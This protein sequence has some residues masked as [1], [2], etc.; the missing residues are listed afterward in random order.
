MKK[1]EKIKKSTPINK[2]KSFKILGAEKIIG[3]VAYTYYGNGN[4]SDVYTGGGSD[5][6]SW[7]WTSNGSGVQTRD[8]FG[9]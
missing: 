4:Q 7:E 5:T 6:Q 2:F 1:L 3:G 9:R 8:Y